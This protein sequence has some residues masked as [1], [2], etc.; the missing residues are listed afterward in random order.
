MSHLHMLRYCTT[1]VLELL[2]FRKRK[3]GENKLHFLSE[4]SRILEE[5]ELV[6]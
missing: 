2:M 1:S 5:G 4:A 6:T 3:H